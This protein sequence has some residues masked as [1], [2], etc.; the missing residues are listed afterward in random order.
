MTLLGIALGGA[1]GALARYGISGLMHRLLGAGFPWGTLS[2]NLMGCFLLGFLLEM[3]RQSGWVSPDFRT[4]AGIGF[5]GAFTTFSTFGV[6]T[7]RAFEAGDWL[8]GALNVLANVA[9]GLLLVAAGTYMARFLTQ[10]VRLMIQ[11]GGGM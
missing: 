8:V 5:L 3:S 7:F 11:T 10:V 2:V 4:I 6:E 1:A 9:G